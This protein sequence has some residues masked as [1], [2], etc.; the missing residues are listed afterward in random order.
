[1]EY[2]FYMSSLILP[3]ADRQ[4]SPFTGWTR[5]H[6][7]VVADHLLASVAGAATEGGSQYRLPGPA[8]RA[9]VESDGLEGYA[10]TFLLAAFRVAG[11]RGQD[12]AGL[13]P[14]YAEG[15]LAGTDPRHPYAWP[16]I[17]DMSQPIVE[18]AS[19]AVALHETRPWLFDRLHPGEQQ[20]VID[21]LAGAVGRRVPDGNWVLFKVVIGQFLASV[22]GPYDPAEIEGGLD[23]IDTWYVGHGWYTDGPGRNF[24]YYCGWALHLYPV[25]WARMS[26]DTA[27]AA[28][29]ARRLGSFLQDYQ[30]FFAP[31]GS[32]LFQ[33]RSLTYRFATAAPLWLGPLAGLELPEPGLTRRI[34]SGVLCHFVDQQVLDDQ[35][36][37]TLG[38][39]EPFQPMIQSYS[40]PASPYWA[41]KAFL[42]LL[43]P[44][45]HPVWTATEMPMPVEQADTTVA[46]P[47]TGWLL[48]GTRRDGVVRLIN[49]GSD[50]A[51]KTPPQSPP[52]PLYTG[53]SYSTHTAPQLGS[54][55]PVDNRITVVAPDRR[56]AQRRFIQ[57]LAAADRFAASVYE[58]GDVR[59]VTASVVGEGAE[60]RV[61]LI[62]APEGHLVRDGGPAVADV[63]KPQT[64]VD[65]AEA[66]V[67]GE[68]GLSSSIRG[69]M[70]FTHAEVHATTGQDAFGPHAAVPYLTARTANEPTYYVSVVTL[71]RSD[72]LP[73][74][75]LLPS[76]GSSITLQWPDRTITT[77]QLRDGLAY[78]RRHPDGAPAY[79]WPS[80]R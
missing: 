62:T 66:R 32:P 44:E 73:Q 40:G 61:H 65:G 45:D 21:W 56:A 43:L 71:T 64:S 12:P 23:R 67:T 20:R 27:R 11:A 24:D 59:V 77:V 53:L 70:G 79:R 17:T 46:I 48:H 6:W 1:M 9:G 7:E 63:Q 76:D 74:V 16:Q 10:R 47:G 42:G 37:L 15:L 69:L 3:P 30:H 41:S 35:G 8:S 2:V 68:D 49:H 34:A 5:Q 26:G 75:H 72:V 78:E 22:G 28:Q 14:R 18:A 80:G 55:D 57:P 54:D 25:L 4:G 51:H 39:H 58:D 52:D 38:W 31:D 33:G 36:R 50:R 60:V 13:L 29:Y 19:I